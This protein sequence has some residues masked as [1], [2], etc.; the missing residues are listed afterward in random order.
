LATA[1]IRP[2]TSDYLDQVF[3]SEA[4]GVELIEVAVTAESDLVGLTEIEACKPGAIP[5]AVR[6][7]DSVD[8]MTASESHA[9]LAPGDVLIALGDRPAADLLRARAEGAT[10]G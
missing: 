6:R 1:A 9:P 3:S 4:T 5:I 8:F 2:H 7:S 10:P